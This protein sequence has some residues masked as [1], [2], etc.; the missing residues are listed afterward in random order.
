MIP[1]N[2]GGVVVNL[3]CIAFGIAVEMGQIGT[4][5]DAFQTLALDASFSLGPGF[6]FCIARFRIFWF[7]SEKLHNTFKAGIEPCGIWAFLLPAFGKA[8]FLCESFHG[9]SCGSSLECLGHG[10]YIG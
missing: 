3:P 1:K 4:Y 10:R 8:D 7:N 6:V 5:L 9:K 2:Y